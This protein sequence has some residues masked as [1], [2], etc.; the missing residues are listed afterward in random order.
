M[1]SRGERPEDGAG[2]VPAES[3]TLHKDELSSKIKEQKVVVDELS[4]LKKNRTEQKC[5]L[6]AKIYWMS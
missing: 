4:N 3:S 1:P 5:F 2:P 6:K